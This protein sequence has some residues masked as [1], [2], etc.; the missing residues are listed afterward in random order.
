MSFRS[1]A[2]ELGIDRK[3]VARIWK[4]YVE[5]EDLLIS[6]ND[7]LNSKEHDSITEFVIGEMNYDSST[8][9]K[10]K[11]TPEIRKRV[12][13]ILDFEDDKTR[14]IGTRHKQRLSAVQVHEILRD[15]GF[16]IGI[17]TVRNFIRSHK[18]SREVFVRQEY[19]MGNRLEYDFGEVKLMI[20]GILVKFYLAVISAPA[21]GFRYAYLYKSQKQEVFLDSHVKFF[22]MVRG[23]YREVVYD[24]MRNVVTTFLPNGEKILNDQCMR[25]ALYYGFEIITTNPR[26][27]N[28]KGTVENSVKVI[29]NQCFTKKYEFDSYEEACDHLEVELERINRKSNV[30]E[31]KNHLLPYRPAYE[32]AEVESC[33][34]NAYSCVRIENNFY[35]VPDYLMNR[36]VTIKNYHDKLLIY[37]LKD[38]VCEHKKIDGSGE[39]QLEMNH[40]LKTF[41]MKPGALKHS[42]VLKQQPELHSIYQS[43]FRTRSK[44]FIA[45]LLEYKEYSIEKIIEILKF[46]GTTLENITYSRNESIEESSRSQLK[47]L[48]QFMN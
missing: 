30:D 8:R 34:V 21:S 10:I 36:N 39:Y 35:S 3:T 31:E 20:S 19:E 42:L 13:D 44:E 16:D 4:K 43:H 40:Y 1:I 17:T 28:E 48:N 18:E 27:G 12:L 11:L 14:K 47:S 26:K 41:A 2:H 29:R 9:T 5:G 46:K 24:N 7:R 38:F 22:E 32:L 25:L 37:S 15:D 33:K 6:T 23:S 45:I